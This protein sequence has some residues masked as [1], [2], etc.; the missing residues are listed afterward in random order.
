MIWWGEEMRN[1]LT[2]LRRSR[3]DSELWAKIQTGKRRILNR[4]A[5]A[6]RLVSTT[7]R[8][9]LTDRGRTYLRTQAFFSARL[10]FIAAY[11][12]VFAI[13]LYRSPNDPIKQARVDAGTA[14]D[15]EPAPGT[16]TSDPQIS[17]SNTV[18]GHKESGRANPQFES[19]ETFQTVGNSIGPRIES[20]AP[21]PE[22]ASAKRDLRKPKDVREVQRRLGDLGFLSANPVGIWG[23]KSK[24]ALVMFKAAIGLPDDVHWDATTEEKLFTDQ[25]PS[26]FVGVWATDAV[27]CKGRDN[28]ESIIRASINEY[29]AQAGEVTCSF[30]NTVQSGKKWSLAAKCSDGAT[31]WISAVRLSVDGHRLT[32]ASQR[33]QLQYQRCSK[34]RTTLALA[35]P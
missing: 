23:P 28:S 8:W 20:L 27:G 4:L 26:G 34:D 5:A 25:P 13:I 10:A 22:P 3:P 6:Q 7:Y 18:A 31:N 9:L 16:N 17:E 14:R 24:Q 15:V 11:V 29:G 35:G 30:H 33:G 19:P 1:F 2:H 21:G 12:F 32:W